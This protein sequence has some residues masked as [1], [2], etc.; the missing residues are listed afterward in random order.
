MD[1]YALLLPSSMKQGA[2]I[3]S[4][5]RWPPAARGASRELKINNESRKRKS[6]RTINK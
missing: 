1:Q 6:Y 5:G 3:N 2:S 4:S